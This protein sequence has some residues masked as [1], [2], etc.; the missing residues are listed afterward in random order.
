MPSKLSPVEFVNSLQ[1][2]LDEKT[3]V[4]GVQQLPD[5]K[6]QGFVDT[7]S[8]VSFTKALSGQD[9]EDVLNSTMLAQLHAN[10]VCDRYRDTERWYKEYVNVLENIGWVIQAFDFN[11]FQTQ[12]RT[13]KLSEICLDLIKALVGDDEQVMKD[14][15]AVF[16]ALSKSEDGLTLFNSKSFSSQGGN[17]QIIP[18]NKDKS[19][20]I[21]AAYFGSYLDVQKTAKDYFF[22]TW[23]SQD[24]KFFYSKEMV[25]LDQE[26]YS[27]VRQAIKDKLG[28]HA[29]DYVH[30][31]DI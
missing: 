26:I 12:Q 2:D 13:F 29:Q 30:N 28:S 17:F 22:F 9:K 21:V 16:T 6:D 10:K 19:G 23:R 31:L 3:D 24:I 27:N 1:L 18:C 11:Q 8:M 15:I 20:Q 7:G 25:T 5:N 4:R 14:V